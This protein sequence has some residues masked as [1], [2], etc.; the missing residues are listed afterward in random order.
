MSTPVEIAPLKLFSVAEA[1]V[2]PGGES[3]FGQWCIADVDLAL[4]LN[5]LVLNGDAVPERLTSCARGQWRR[6][7][8]QLWVNQIRPLL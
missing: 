6:P 2:P 8:G 4:V 5:R 1:L 3:L 7:S